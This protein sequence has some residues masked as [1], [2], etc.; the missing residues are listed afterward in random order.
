MHK[1]KCPTSSEE[2]DE[3]TLGEAGAGRCVFIFDTSE[4]ATK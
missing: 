2:Y 1:D 4:D 3:N